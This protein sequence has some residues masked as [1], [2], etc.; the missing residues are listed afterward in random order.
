MR[1]VEAATTFRDVFAVREFRALWVAHVLSLI[2]DQFARVALSYLVYDQTGSTL[3]TALTYAIGF[4]PWLVGGPL[5]SGLADRVPRRTVMVVADLLRAALVGLMV[6]PGVPLAGLLVLLFLAE[7]CAPPFASARAALLP[8][9]LEGELYVVGSAVNTITWEA[10]QVV[11]FVLGGAYV[12]VAGVRGAL[13]LD[14]ATFVVSAL[15]IA[16]WVRSRPAPDREP[17]TVSGMGADL[18]AGARLVFGDPWL[19]TLTVLAWLCAVYMVPEALA[20][21]VAVEL[22]GGALAVGLLL[23]A[24]PI[25]TTIGSVLIGRWVSPARRLRWLVPMAFLTGVPLI[26][27][28]WW[29]DLFVIGV[30]WGLSGLFSAYNLAANAAFVRAVPDARRG[31]AFGLVQAGMAVGQGVGFLVAGAA[32]ERAGLLTVVAIAGALTCAVALVLGLRRPRS[33]APA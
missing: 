27:C 4:L 24:N 8:Q 21:P 30:L 10:A 3:L 15:V 29:T 17:G 33:P 23:A 22:G 26:A 31:Q 9:V 18:R 25:G 32:A 12:A 1:D 28:L 16:L 14:A 6:L 5:L 7:L 13:M 19:R 20:A 11:G 2:G